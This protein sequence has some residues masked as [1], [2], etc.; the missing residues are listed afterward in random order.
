MRLRALSI[1]TNH[2]SGRRDSASV[3]LL[4]SGPPPL[5]LV[6]GGSEQSHMPKK[7]LT[8]CPYCKTPV[9]R[10]DDHVQRCPRRKRVEAEMARLKLKAMT[11]EW[12]EERRRRKALG[13]PRQTRGQQKEGTSVR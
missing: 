2:S 11:D 13:G 12:C 8:P 3:V 4:L 1:P 9:K 7:E 6:L 5:S 10:L